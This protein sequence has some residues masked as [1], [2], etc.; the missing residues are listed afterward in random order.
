M[1]WGNAVL[2]EDQ[3]DVD[4]CVTERGYEAEVPTWAT[5]GSISSGLFSASRGPQA[6]KGK[7][8]NDGFEDIV[9]ASGCGRISGKTF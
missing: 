6:L 8:A 1:A 4:A 7:T 3:N 9:G 2:S 5:A